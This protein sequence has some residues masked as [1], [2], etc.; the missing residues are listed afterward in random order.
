MFF[1]W[2]YLLFV[3]AAFFCLF[4]EVQGSDDDIEEFGKLATSDSALLIENGDDLVKRLDNFQKAKEIINEME[5]K[6]KGATFKIN[7]FALMS[8]NEEKKL[9]AAVSESDEENFMRE[10]RSAF[11]NTISTTIPESFDWRSHGKVTPAKDQIGDICG[12]CWAF[13]AMGAIESQYLI[14]FNLSLDLSEQYAVSCE[15]YAS[16]KCNGGSCGGTF[17]LA[18]ESGIPTEDC[19]PYTATNGTCTNKC[20]YQNKYH[21]TDYKW[22]GY[23]ES[24]YAAA[25]Y[26]YGPLTF[27]FHVPKAFYYYSSG[28][29]DIPNSECTSTNNAGT[30]AMLLVGYTKDY[31]IAK[32]SFG[33]EWGE[34]GFVRFKRGVNFCNMTRSTHSVY[35]APSTTPPPTNRPITPAPANPDPSILGCPNYDGITKLNSTWRSVILK[36]FNSQRSEL[37]NGKILAFN[38]TAFPKVKNMRK[39]V[40][41]CSIEAGLQEA[42]KNCS[43]NKIRDFKW[44]AS[45]GRNLY[46]SGITAPYLETRIGLFAQNRNVTAFVKD[47]TSSIYSSQFFTA[48]ADTTSFACWYV[49]SDTCYY[50]ENIAI[51][52]GIY[53]VPNVDGP[54]YE[55]GNPC[56]QDS[57]CTKPGVNKCDTNL[58]LCYPAPATTTSTTTTTTTKAT[59]T[60]T[61]PPVIQCLNGDGI[62]TLNQKWR[63]YAAYVYNAKRATVAAGHQPMGNGTSFPPA[64]IMN[65]LIYNCSIEA[66]ARQIANTCNFQNTRNW[67]LFVLPYANFFDLNEADFYY[68]IKRNFEQRPTTTIAI[69][70][71]KTFVYNSDFPA[72]FGAATSFGCHYS[73]NDTCYSGRKTV[74]YCGIYPPP[75][76]NQPLYEVVSPLPTAPSTPAISC[77]NY[78]GTTKLN[79]AQRKI[80]LDALNINRATLAAGLMQMVNTT[81]YPKA[82]NMKKLV[83]SCALE[84]EAQKYA[85][86]CSNQNTFITSLQHTVLYP[87]SEYD[88]YFWI[89]KYFEN[90]PDAKIVSQ[91]GT[92]FVYHPT[93][94]SYPNFPA[95]PFAWDSLTSVG[96]WYSYN[97]KCIPGMKTVLYCALS[98]TPS[99]T[100]ALYEVGNP[101]TQDSHCTKS[102]ANKCDILMKLC[103]SN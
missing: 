45:W 9:F 53:P 88:F 60:T 29:L 86:N 54:I 94:P 31:W 55:A 3:F 57:H 68:M 97:D 76:V 14:R 52:C 42:A 95:F 23:N 16:H 28:I 11:D 5:Q 71:G 26:N 72:A 44:F 69:Q 96:C 17:R 36:T 50:N 99:S 1:Q 73:Y 92:S 4:L 37:A 25:I 19:E 61:K 80:I 90:R 20:D 48:F 30:H 32:N 18:M 41:N 56:T 64:K 15:T 22:Q 65:Q 13:T 38:E 39:L 102:G 62:K 27:S 66:E 77:T 47:G 24:A 81:S 10:K 59:T 101:C 7:K 82:R 74:L 91:N 70:N 6:Y 46:E 75:I 49:D 34:N 89:P 93:F 2:R 85:T 33:A 63:N 51:Y 87:I 35:L 8:Q 83:Y 103:Y 100:A 98:P 79:N 40:Y 43:F 78:D 21:V 84:A 58:G 12:S 67:H